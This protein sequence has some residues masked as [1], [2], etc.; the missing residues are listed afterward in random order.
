MRR[1]LAVGVATAVGI[2]I[3]LIAVPVLGAELSVTTPDGA[4]AVGPASVLVAGVV[5]G[6]AGW[7]SLAVLER[8]TTGAAK[9][10]TVL[11]LALTVVSLLGPVGQAQSLEATLALGAM[12]L[13]VG[14]ALIGL[15]PARGTGPTPSAGDR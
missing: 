2:G 10:W 7:G 15:L 8:L 11:A 12:H 13:G 1:L 9:V 3:W 6:L 5:A 14:A 4:M